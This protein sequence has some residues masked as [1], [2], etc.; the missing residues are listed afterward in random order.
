MTTSLFPKR[1][2]A[3]KKL[4]FRICVGYAMLGWRRGF[5]GGNRAVA[6]E[7]ESALCAEGLPPVMNV[8]A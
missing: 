8:V 7:Q 1:R 2:I 5:L 6:E 3:G 4:H